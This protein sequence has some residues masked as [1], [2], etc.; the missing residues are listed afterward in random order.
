MIWN[1]NC[2]FGNHYKIKHV[3]NLITSSWIPSYLN[4]A[5][6]CKNLEVVE[7]TLLKQTINVHINYAISC[8][9]DLKNRVSGLY[10]TLLLFLKLNILRYKRKYDIAC[11][12][13]K[14]KLVLLHHLKAWEKSVLIL[15]P[16]SFLQLFVVYA[17]YT[18]MLHFT[19]VWL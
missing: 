13:E 19:L 1:E 4:I 2:F 17:N 14:N 18:F 6:T 5:G 9:N 10:P 16:F 15:R 3:K 7:L 11:K 8:I 12:L